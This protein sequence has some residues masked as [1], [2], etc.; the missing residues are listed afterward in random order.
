MTATPD[1]RHETFPLLPYTK[2]YGFSYNKINFFTPSYDNKI[3]GIDLRI[4]YSETSFSEVACRCGFSEDYKFL[5][6]GKRS[7][8]VDSTIDAWKPFNIIIGNYCSIAHDITFVINLNHDYLSV[9]TYPWKSVLGIGEPNYLQ[10]KCQIIIGND[11]TIGE[12]A[13]ILGGV[14]IGNGAVIGANAVVTKDIPPYAIVAGNPA[15]II[16]YR[17]DDVIIDKLNSIKWWYWEEQD[18]I[19]N[20]LFITGNVESFVDKFYISDN[21]INSAADLDGLHADGYQL[22]AFIPDFSDDYSVWYQVI[23]EYLAKFSNKDKV[24]LILGL[25]QNPEYEQFIQKILSMIKEYGEKAPKI[26]NVPELQEVMLRVIKS[27]DY[28]IT[29]RDFKCLYYSDYAYD[30]GTKIISGLN[31][32]ILK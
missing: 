8:V 14:M 13:T 31:I 12:K 24:A 28:F 15:K 19:A 32:P 4:K 27:A 29:T 6:I 11:V 1:L 26:F 9:S 25:D 16:K 20:Q 22:Y 23:H 21:P 30:Y 7:Y 2:F 17:F 5:S 18:I 10:R 3:G